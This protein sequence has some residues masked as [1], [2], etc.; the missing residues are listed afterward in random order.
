[1]SKRLKNIF[2]YMLIGNLIILII[3]TFIDLPVSLVLY[4]PSSWFGNFFAAYGALPVLL[5]LYFISLVL[6]NNAKQVSKPLTK[7]LNLVF[8]VVIFTAVLFINWYSGVHYLKINLIVSGVITSVLFLVVSYV[9]YHY[10]FLHTDLKRIRKVAV[11]LG[12]SV[13]ATLVIVFI[14]KNIWGRPRMR[15]LV[16]EDSIDLFRNWW[17][18]D[19]S[20]KSETSFFVVLSEEFRSFPSGHTANAA[21][22]MFLPVLS[23]MNTKLKDKEK[24]LFVIGIG[25][26]MLVAISRIIIGA[27]FISDVTVS[28]L[29]TLLI[30]YAGF[31][32]LDNRL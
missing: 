4:N 3:S 23:I 30:V 15:Y 18:I 7:A 28:F 16:N 31:S 25:W 9:S 19:L 17:Q 22:M 1:M 6:F 26:T 5:C 29:I 24:V 32:F 21:L 2:K 10:I 27:H 13:V 14:I 20:L 11:V 12:I 8:G